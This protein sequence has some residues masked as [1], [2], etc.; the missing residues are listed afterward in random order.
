MQLLEGIFTGEI[1]VTQIHVRATTAR[2]MMM[3]LII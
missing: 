3:T 2:R 1:E